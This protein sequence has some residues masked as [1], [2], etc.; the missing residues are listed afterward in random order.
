MQRK[1]TK[2]TPLLP[3]NGE[4]HAACYGTFTFW[5]STRIT[6][7]GL[8]EIRKIFKSEDDPTPQCVRLVFADWYDTRDFR[9][10]VYRQFKSFQAHLSISLGIPLHPAY[11]DYMFHYVDLSAVPASPLDLES[12][13][14]PTAL[15]H[16][17]ISALERYVDISH[18][19][20]VTDYVEPAPNVVTCSM[21]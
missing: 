10:I 21:S 8:C 5:G 15:H 12:Q 7:K 11:P 2:E 9:D 18:C 3:K 4:P 6:P 19:P 1:L 20:Q 16:I 17:L 13:R 14:A